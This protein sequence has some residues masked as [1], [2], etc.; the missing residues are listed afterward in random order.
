MSVLYLLGLGE[1]SV[2]AG[3]WPL[4]PFRNTAAARARLR[5][6][7]HTDTC[8]HNIFPTHEASPLSLGVFV[9]NTVVY[10]MLLCRQSVDSQCGCRLKLLR[11]LELR[12]QSMRPSI[13]LS[14]LALLESNP[15]VSTGFL[16]AAL[17]GN[18]VTIS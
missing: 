3:Q 18:S 10:F 2:A 8:V 6:H 14:L 11:L 12:P 16:N 17:L 4:D 7:T 15:A 13:T 9:K 1:E 5:A